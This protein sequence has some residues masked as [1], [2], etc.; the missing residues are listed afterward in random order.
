MFIFASIYKVIVKNLD[1]AH[2]LDFYSYYYYNLHLLYHKILFSCLIEYTNKNNRLKFK[3]NNY[4][5][6]LRFTNSLLINEYKEK[7]T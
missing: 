3:L 6:Q 4:N 2:N 5:K 1:N 7:N